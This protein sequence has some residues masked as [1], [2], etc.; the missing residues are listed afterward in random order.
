MELLILWQVLLAASPF[1]FMYWPAGQ[2]GIEQVVSSFETIVVKPFE[3]IAQDRSIVNGFACGVT[4]NFPAGQ[5]P[6]RPRIPTDE[7]TEEVADEGNAS[8]HFP[9]FWS[10]NVCVKPLLSNTA[11]RRN[12]KKVVKKAHF[13]F[14]VQ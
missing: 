13:Y 8:D 1:R 9:P 2:L 6:Y 5:Q 4:M 11:K 3:Q 7:G 14:T 10:H 12:R